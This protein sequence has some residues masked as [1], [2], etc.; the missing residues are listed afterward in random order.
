M[1]W[2]NCK[3]KDRAID[4]VLGCLLWVIG[5]EDTSCRFTKSLDNERKL[6]NP[7]DMDR[8]S[9]SLGNTWTKKNT[10]AMGCRVLKPLGNLSLGK[11]PP[12]EKVTSCPPPP[13][14]TQEWFYWPPYFK[15][16]TLTPSVKHDNNGF[17]ESGF[18]LEE[19]GNCRYLGLG[20]HQHQMKQLYSGS[21]QD[22]V[23]SL[24]QDPCSNQLLAPPSED[25]GAP[26]TLFQR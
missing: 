6:W 16:S 15:V 21:E 12:M 14:V 24:V 7:Q 26:H 25:V 17:Y 5:H 19:G 22:G 20:Y 13:N 9:H 1:T 8:K 18:Y 3:R 11:Y 4:I 23:S 10:P 2:F